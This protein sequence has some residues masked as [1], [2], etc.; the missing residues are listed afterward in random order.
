MID[1]VLRF[2]ALCDFCKQSIVCDHPD[3]DTAILYFATA[4]EALAAFSVDPDKAVDGDLDTDILAGMIL[5]ADTLPGHPAGMHIC[6]ACLLPLLC[7]LRG[8][9][10]TPWRGCL[11]AMNTLTGQLVLA[12]LPD[13]RGLPACPEVRDCT[14]PGCQHHEERQGVKV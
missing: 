3:D 6:F 5:D 11:C 10:L 2:Q 4:A 12:R 7:E 1:T 9:R 13:H 14:R 8:H